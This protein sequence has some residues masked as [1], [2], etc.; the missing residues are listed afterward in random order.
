MTKLDAS[1]DPKLKS[2]VSSANEPSADFPIQNLP[3][4][5]FTDKRNPYARVGVA[6]GDQIL[7]LSVLEQMHLLEP[8]PGNP[9]FDKEWR[10]CGLFN[11]GEKRTVEVTRAANGPTDDAGVR[12]QA[13]PSCSTY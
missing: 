7:D 12:P 6:I 1:H 9:V 13:S 3:F 11:A 4:G 10:Q 5:V 2:W 8:A